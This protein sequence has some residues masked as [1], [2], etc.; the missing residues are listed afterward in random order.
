MLKGFRD[1]IMR[2]NVVDLAIAVVIGAAFGAVVTALVTDIITPIVA[3]IGGQ[4][5]FSKLTF[6]IHHSK[7]FYGA[8]INAILSFLVIAAALYF[9]VVM[10]L[11]RL[12]ERRAARL[13]KGEPD[14]APKPEEVILLE[15]I[16]DLLAT[17]STSAT[18]T[19][20]SPSPAP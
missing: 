4:P 7:F 12:A 11:N 2:G 8:F 5:D 16:R 17:G 3:A 18:T 6:T 20:T 1:F 19:S 13:S 9:I 15:Q 14:P 10:P